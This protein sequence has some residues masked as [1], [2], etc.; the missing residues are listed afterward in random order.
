MI[1]K[2]ETMDSKRK[3]S[4]CA[5]EKTSEAC[6]KE[7]CR[8]ELIRPCAHY[9]EDYAQ[10]VREDALQRPEGERI[11]VPPEEILDKAYRYEH[12]INMEE[13]RVQETMFWLVDRERFIG[14]IKI[15]HTLTPALLNYGG[16]IGYIVRPQECGKGYGSKMLAM[17]LDYAREALKLEK[18][19]ITCDDDN[20]ASARVIEKNGG[21]LENKVR[22]STQR[23]EVT[24][25]RYWINLEGEKE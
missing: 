22:N 1:Y 16:H 5:V 14:L 13:W 10:A 6:Q 7:P 3:E 23:G 25:R 8:M 9:L 15:R 12:G 2:G 21:V 11:F 20:A 18:V 19:L 24:S 17:A 4:P